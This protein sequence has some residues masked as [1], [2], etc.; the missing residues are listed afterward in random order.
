MFDAAVAAIAPFSVG[1]RA[2]SVGILFTDV[3]TSAS[4]SYLLVAAQV[5]NGEGSKPS[6]R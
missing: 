2:R 3:H 6:S 5:H 4:V 1:E